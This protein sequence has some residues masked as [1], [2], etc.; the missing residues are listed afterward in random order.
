MRKTG[1]ALLLAFCFC[2]VLSSARAGW[3]P[4]HRDYKRS[5]EENAQL[6]IKKLKKIDP[7][8]NKIFDHAVGWAVFPEIGKAGIGIGGAG[9]NGKVYRKGEFIGTTTMTQVSVGFQF[10]G[11]IYGEI[12]FFQDDNTLNKFKNGKFELGANVSAV[13]FDEGVAKTL[14]FKDGTI[15]IVMPKKGIMYEATVSGQKFTFKAK[16]SKNKK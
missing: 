16:K 15:V 7:D 14:G 10:G 8:I 4:F 12:I 1:L 11:Q 6:F 9:G 13:V 3:D 5:G 2:L